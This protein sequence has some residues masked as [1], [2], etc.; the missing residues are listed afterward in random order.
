MTTD[1]LPHRRYNPLTGDWVLVSPQRTQRPWKGQVEKVQATDLPIY[2]PDCYLCPGNPRAAGHVNPNYKDTYVFDN[3]FPALFK[4]APTISANEKDSIQAGVGGDKKVRLLRAE[5][6]SGI[7]RVV[8]FSPRH[9]LSLPELSNNQVKAVVNTWIEQTRR[10]S[11]HEFIRYVQI[12]ENRGAI[13]GASNPH[14]H[15][16]IWATADIPNEPEKERLT[17]QSYLNQHGSCLLCDY[18]QVEREIGERVILENDSFMALV[19]YWAIWPFESMVLAKRHIPMMQDLLPDEIDALADVLRRL[20][21]RYDNIFNSPFPYSMGFHQAPVNYGVHPE[22][23]FHA[24]YY[25]PLLRSATIRKFM[26][27]FELLASP[28]R[29]ITAEQAAQRLRTVSE[30]HFRSAE[31]LSK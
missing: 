6:E 15:C 5:P 22:W 25:P 19:P 14:P 12:F 18:A 13:M 8:C 20:T 2:D 3:D 24:H 30:V 21:T 11:Q 23:H 27:G 4:F 26:V 17:Q 1:R 16:Q 7:C 31:N 9:D 10:L 29:D 28:Q